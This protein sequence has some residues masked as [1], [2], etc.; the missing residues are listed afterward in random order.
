MS[1]VEALR[2]YTINAA[3]AGFDETI[4][5]PLAF[6]RIGAATSIS[7]PLPAS[8]RR[9]ATPKKLCVLSPAP[10]SDRR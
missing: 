2:S 10:L 4:K 8:C 5:G 1:R 7:P 6:L 3:Y 9:V